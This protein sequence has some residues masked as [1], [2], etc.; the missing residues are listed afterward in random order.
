[1]KASAIYIIIFLFVGQFSKA[2]NLNTIIKDPDLNS[3][4]VMVGKCNRDGLKQGEYGLYFKSQYEVY[5]PSEK[6]IEKMKTKINLVD[7]TVVFGTWCSDSRIQVPRFYKVLDQAG[8]NEKRM[9]II[10]VSRKK[11]AFTTNIEYL[12]IKLVPT[13]IIY[14]NGKE[15][16]RITETPKKSLENDLSKIIN[17]AKL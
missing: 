13:F 6:Y 11:E 5:K 7:I 2:Q 9:T 4:E 1:M 8:Y 3:K 16:G 17:K 10:G 14:Q 12:D 15:L